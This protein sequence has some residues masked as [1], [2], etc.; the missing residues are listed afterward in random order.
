MFNSKLAFVSFTFLSIILF[1]TACKKD[2]CEG[3]SPTYDTTVKTIIDNSCAYSGCHDGNTGIGPGDYTT[4]A[5]LQTIINNGK[6]KTR[7]VDDR[8]DAT[9]GM[10][11]DASVY[12]V[13]MK[14]DL[15]ESELNI[16]ECWISDG[17]PES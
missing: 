5:G 8:A 10:P 14:D 6:F 9:I 7:V 4:Y 12:P 1:F 11:P 16:I 15:T 3:L 13:S 17:Y 2:D